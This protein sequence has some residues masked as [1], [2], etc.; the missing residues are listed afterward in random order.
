MNKI[1][2]YILKWLGAYKLR[3]VVIDNKIKALENDVTLLMNVINKDD[4]NIVITSKGCA[5]FEIDIDT[6]VDAIHQIVDYGSYVY[7][8]ELKDIVLKHI[9]LSN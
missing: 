7:K 8:N 3:G 9:N 1:K 5:D 2:Q 4:D 6:M